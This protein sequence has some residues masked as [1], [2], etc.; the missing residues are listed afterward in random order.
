MTADVVDIRTR[1]RVEG[2]DLLVSAEHGRVL[3]QIGEV[4]ITLTP[5]QAFEVESCLVLARHDAESSE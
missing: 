2:V 1:R 3:I 5:A 4:S